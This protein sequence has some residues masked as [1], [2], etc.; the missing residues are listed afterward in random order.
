MSYIIT[1]T[2]GATLT[3]LADDTV[4]TTSTSLSLVGK[5]YAGYGI[6]LNENFV[7]LLENFSN[8]NSPKAPLTGQLWYDSTNTLIKFYTGSIW[9]PLHTSAASPTA[10]PGP[11]QGDLWWN[12]TTSQLSVYGGGTGS[13][14]WVII[15]P[16]YTSTAGTS[17]AIAETVYDT[18]NNPHIVVKLY[19]NSYVVAIFNY[20]TAFSIPLTGSNAITGFSTISPGVTLIS[21]ASLSGAQFSGTAN[22]STYFNSLS[23]S[24]FLRSDAG[25]NNGT[26]TL[27][28]GKL[29]A[30]S[31]LLIDPSATDVQIFSNGTGIK[32]IGIYVNKG[33]TQTKAINIS[34]S[35]GITQFFANVS[36][37][38]IIPTN[39]NQY[40][41]GLSASRFAN[42]FSVGVT[43]TNAYT[44][45]VYATNLNT[46]NI[47][48]S[49][50]SMATGTLS[51]A[52]TVNT[53]GGI[54]AII[55]GASG[56]GVGNIGTAANP[57]NTVFAR[58]TSA[59]YA[60]VAERF[61]ADV[62]MAP[63]TVV[64]LGGIK[65]ITQAVQELSE[66]VF[67]VISTLPGFLLNGTAGS[68][69]THPAVAVNGRVPVRVIGRVNKGDRL[70]SAGRGLA[71]AALRSEMT[72]FN[73]IGR[74]LEDK[75]TDGEGMIEAIVKL[76]S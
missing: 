1:T 33:S 38:Y 65:E 28:V 32:D 20:G 76:N 27:G 59:Q 47:I 8:S 22:N 74:A 34:G 44:A 7:Q 63:G 11:V 64:E 66:A 58:A 67:G 31:D 49:S 12:T 70:V 29:Q 52:L 19:V 9:K 46:T 51:G 30:G 36:S 55:N 14:A 68:D 43:T 62:P 35:S 17:G 72:A 15:G 73:V 18:G 40:T 56:S 4:N 2:A 61:E 24:Q 60:D 45:N 37:Q 5:N 42:V 6:F 50:L 75:T 53:G 48:G 41:L 16:A 3:T 57:F 69:D 21:S 71:R 23:S 10:P 39:D 25:S 13:S 54:N 26:Y